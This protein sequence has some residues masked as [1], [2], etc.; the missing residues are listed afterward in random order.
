MVGD[1]TAAVLLV[2][3]HSLFHPRLLML[4]YFLKIIRVFA[5]GHSRRLR[6]LPGLGDERFSRAEEGRDGCSDGPVCP[7]SLEKKNTLESLRE[8]EGGE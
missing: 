7:V 2:I 8:S 1:I 3:F 5:C 6:P 4:G